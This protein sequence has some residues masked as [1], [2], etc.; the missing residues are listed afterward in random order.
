MKSEMKGYEMQ[1][2]QQPRNISEARRNKIESALQTLQDA[3][4]ESGDDLKYLLR[5][6]FDTVKDF[7]AD[8]VDEA[9]ELSSD[10]K[11]K[12]EKV[13]KR[14]QQNAQKTMKQIDKSIH[15]NPWPYIGGGAAIGLVLG[16]LLGSRRH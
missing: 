11:A 4:K 5:E 13:F 6:K 9:S 16:I 7:V 2:Q 3:A 15:E 10:F 8:V 14:T 1:Q 12:A